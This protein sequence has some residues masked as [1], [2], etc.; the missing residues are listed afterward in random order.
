M[1]ISP[2]PDWPAC[3]PSSCRG[4]GE[5]QFALH[6]GAP[7]ILKY[8][9]LQSQMRLDSHAGAHLMLPAPLLEGPPYLGLSTFVRPDPHVGAHC[10]L[11]APPN[12]G[13]SNC[14]KYAPC[15]PDQAPHEALC[16][17]H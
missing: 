2:I 17:L 4:T 9:D 12:I 10:M 14:V 15:V 6:D 16:S 1:D 13:R 7:S 3:L 5:V 8:A 11:P